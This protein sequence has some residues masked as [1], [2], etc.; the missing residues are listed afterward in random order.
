MGLGEL[1]ISDCELRICSTDEAVVIQ[2]KVLQN[3]NPQS[4]I[5]N[6]KFIYG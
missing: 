3:T 6:P 5:A 2:T 1:R 4:E